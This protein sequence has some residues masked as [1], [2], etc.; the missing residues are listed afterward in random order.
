[1]TAQ[2]D[3]VRFNQ[4]HRYATKGN[5]TA[6]LPI[7]TKVIEKNPKNENAFRER[8][9]CYMELNKFDESLADYNK[10][11]E[12]DPSDGLAYE[13]RGILYSLKKMNTEALADF[14]SAIRLDSCC[15]TA[16]CSCGTLML[17]MNKYDDAEKFFRMAIQVAP[18]KERPTCYTNLGYTYLLKGNTKRAIAHL[19]LAITL[20]PK[21]PEAYKYRSQAY[22]DIQNTV[23]S[24]EDAAK[25]KKL[26]QKAIK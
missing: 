9:S 18:E 14:K 23:A 26:S 4:A 24:E 21:S 3:S 8:G 10:A 12:M 6:A 16:Y 15:A 5:F 7:Y 2:A 1:M 22:R 13:N 17:G 19:S 11:I 20:S 25:Y